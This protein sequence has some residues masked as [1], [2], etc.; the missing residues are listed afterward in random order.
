MPAF[1]RGL[2]SLR[3]A[4]I[5]M[6]GMSLASACDRQTPTTSAPA[7]STSGRAP[8]RGGAIVFSGPSPTPAVA[9]RAPAPSAS[10]PSAASAS[11]LSSEYP[12]FAKPLVGP[13]A[14]PRA[15][16][17]VRKDYDRSARFLVQQALVAHPE[18]KVVAEKA[19]APGELDLYETIYGVKSFAPKPR[20]EPM[21][22]EAVIARCAD[23]DTCNRVAAMFLAVSPGERIELVCGAPLQTTGGFSRVRELARDLLAIPDE[24]SPMVAYCGRALACL[25]REGLAKRPS[26][27]CSQLKLAALRAC[28]VQASCSNVAAC[29][30]ASRAGAVH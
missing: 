25:A 4:A 27:A 5:A 3:R 12:A 14:D 23:I 11:R 29:V 6:M 2:A 13:C 10:L 17:A 26:L 8:A 20:G 1:E 22:S 19:Q 30:E 18:F 21:Y 7:S 9:P 15:V 24:K 28:A 16:L